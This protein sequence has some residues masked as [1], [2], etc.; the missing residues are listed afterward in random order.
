[1][2][3]QLRATIATVAALALLALAA[4]AA[5]AVITPAGV[6]VSAQATD[7]ELERTG[8]GYF[9]IRCTSDLTGR[10]ALDGRALSFRATFSG[11]REIITFSPITITC[12]GSITFTSISST[13]G[14]EAT[15]RTRLDNDLECSVDWP[16]FNCSFTFRG[17]QSLTGSPVLQ[18]STQ[19]LQV[20]ATVMVTGSGPAPCYGAQPLYF[21]ATYTISGAR[22]TIS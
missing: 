15:F 20:G 18:Q 14:R 1:M 11:C 16:A 17:P 10:V 22:L 12:R 19:R 3:P 5:H 21:S 8:A 7:F 9:I 13:A 4:P 6:A 2:A